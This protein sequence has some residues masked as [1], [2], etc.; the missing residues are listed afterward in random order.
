MLADRVAVS[1]VARLA[2]TLALLFGL[3]ASGKT[4]SVFRH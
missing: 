2:R 4:T 3:Q 1:P